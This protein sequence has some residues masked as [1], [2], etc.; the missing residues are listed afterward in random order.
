MKENR[1]NDG[2]IIC[3]LA[4]DDC[5]AVYEIAKVSIPECW[6]LQGIQ[7]VLK[8]NHNFF[9]VAKMQQT[10]EIVGY[11]GLM[12]VA[13][14]AEILNIAVKENY[15]TFGIGQLLM[16]RLLEQAKEQNAVR[17]LLEVRESNAVAY[18]LYKKNNFS[19]LT[20]RKDYYTNPIENAVIMERF[21]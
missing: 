12:V 11:A 4:F 21:T 19:E 3:P 7:D 20:I 8:Y 15:R 16:D 5:E 2:I 13:D 18:H 1:L 9:F 10:K 17:V 14:E 6:S